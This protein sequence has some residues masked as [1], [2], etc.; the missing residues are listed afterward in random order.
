MSRNRT[1]FE[2]SRWVPMTMSTVPSARPASVR[3]CSFGATNRLRIPTLTGKRREPGPERLVVLGSEDGRRDEDRDLLP[4][5]GRL[6]RAAERDLGLAVPDIADDEAV[7]RPAGLHVVLH[8]EDRT[9]LVDGLLV[10]E[11]RLHLGLPRRV[12]GVGIAGRV[13]TGGVEREELLGE[14]RDRVPDALLRA[15]PLRA[16]QLRQLRALAARVAGDTGDLLDRDEDPVARGEADL[17]IV[18]LIALAGA[19][20]EH[21]LVAGDAVV[22][23]DDEVAGRQALEDVPRYHPPH[24]LGP[25]NPDVAEQ[26]AVRDE[27]RPS[28]PP[29]NPP[30]RLRSTRTIAPGGGGSVTL[31]V[32]PAGWPASARSSASRGAWSEATTMRGGVPSPAELRPPA[33]DGVPE[34]GGP[35]RWQRRL[36]PTE[37]VAGREATA[38]DRGVA[39]RLPTPS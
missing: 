12:G 38:G 9:E 36:A 3:S 33:L 35:S 14:V 6:E 11:A 23:V 31:P 19:A 32:M 13:G 34:L 16:A 39:C 15:Q 25:S 21:P 18:A 10:R 8:L 22:D 30:F 29:A 28:G 27:D 1:S 24:R 2:S 20:P 4:V 17:E 26:L 37:S 5:L 7:H